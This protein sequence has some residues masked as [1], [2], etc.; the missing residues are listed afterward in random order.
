[1][2][3][4]GAENPGR[5]TARVLPQAGDEGGKVVEAAGFQ[6]MHGLVIED[7]A[8]RTVF[9]YDGHDIDPDTVRAEAAKVLK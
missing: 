4:I 5:I 8:G 9:K 3:G 6:K 1:M 2:N 7:A